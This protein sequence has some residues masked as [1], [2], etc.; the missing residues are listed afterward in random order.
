MGINIQ[1]MQKDDCDHVTY[2]GPIDAEAEVHLSQ[3]LPKLGTRVVFN[4]QHVESVNSC[5]VR[6]WINFMRELQKGER[7]ITFEGCTSEIVMQINMIP[8]FMGG[9]KVTSV[10]GGYVCDECGHEE[11]VLFVAGKN[12][13]EDPDDEL[14]TVTCSQCGAEMELEEMEEDFFAFLSA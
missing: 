13:P 3:I 8:S 6:S 1:I 11:N 7:D 14:A 10:Y 4:F 5:G 12:L 2:T 9:A